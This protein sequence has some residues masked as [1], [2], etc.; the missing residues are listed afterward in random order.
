[1][2]DGREEVSS[3]WRE[4]R[5]PPTRSKTPLLCAGLIAV[6]YS[7]LYPARGKSQS[8]RRKLGESSS[9]ERSECNI[10]VLSDQ[11]EFPRPSPYPT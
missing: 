11:N 4:E 8:A 7:D 6:D 9:P 3:K 1:M 10:E 2:G 5:E